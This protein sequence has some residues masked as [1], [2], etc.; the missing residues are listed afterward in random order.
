MGS[1]ISA[2]MLNQHLAI[3]TEGMELGGLWAPQEGYGG[4]WGDP[5]VPDSDT[6]TVP[7]GWEHWRKAGSSASHPNLLLQDQ[8]QPSIPQVSLWKCPGMDRTPPILFT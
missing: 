3:G 2:G 6:G 5:A 1:V 7:Y 8:L 4:H